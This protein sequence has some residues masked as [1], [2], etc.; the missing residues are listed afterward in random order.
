MFDRAE[1]ILWDSYGDKNFWTARQSLQFAS[2][3]QEIAFDFLT[4]HGLSPS[5]NISQLGLSSTN[6]SETR[7]SLRREYLSLHLRRADFML[8]RL[9][10]ELPTIP[11]TARQIMSQLRILGLAEVFIA[12]DATRMGKALS[13]AINFQCVL[14]ILFTTD[15][16]S[17][18]KWQS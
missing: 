4:K 9:A 15:L 1:V 12:T 10:S 5:I 18:Q 6:N 2:R 3:L 11:S 17:L 14:L 8:G 13:T 16:N 7:L